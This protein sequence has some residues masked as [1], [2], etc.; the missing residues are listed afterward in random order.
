MAGAV[1]IVC[2]PAG[3]GKT[4]RLLERFRQVAGSGGAALWLCPTRR[5]AEALA[6]GLTDFPATSLRM[7]QD[8]ADEVV[9]HNDPGARPFSAVQRRLLIESLLADLHARGRLSHFK[10]VIDTRGF[11]A[12]A[13]DLIAELK[14]NEIWPE[15]FAE[16]V[17][18]LPRG[19]KRASKEQQCALLYDAYQ[20]T[21]IR[22]QFYDLEGRVWYARDL[23][24]KGARQPFAEVRAVFLD[25]FTRFTRTQHEI[26]E[27]LRGWVDEL[28]I[29]LPDEPGE[30]RAELFSTPR[31][32]LALLPEISD[33][34]RAGGVSPLVSD[35]P[36]GLRPPLARPAGL[37]HLERQ[38]FRPVRSVCPGENAEGLLLIEAPGLV[39]EVRMVARQVK[40]LLLAGVR[41]D[42]ILVTMRDAVPYADLL[43][44][45]FAEYGVP[46]DIE[47]AEPIL[48]NPAVATLLRAL[49][50]P[51]GEWPFGPV[52][53]LL[54]STY[55]RPNWPEGGGEPDIAQHA[56]ALLRLLG[57]PRGR[58]AYLRAVERWAERVQPG[59]EDED[60]EESR[61][62]R[63]H[64]LAKKCRPFLERLFRAWDDFPTKAPLAE[65]AAWLFRFAEDLGLVRAAAE[66]PRDR[67][68][69]DR[70]RDELGRWLDTGERLQLSPRALDRGRFLR[71]LS[72]LAAE[73]GLARAPR[74]PGRVRVLS[75]EL[76]RHLSAAYLFVMGLGER[77]FP[78]LAPALPLLDEH[79]R[80]TLRQ[81]GL[82]V[83][84]QADLMA[85]EMLLFYQ[86]VTQA[87]RALVLSYPA[88]DDKGQ[89]LL[90]SSFLSTVLDCFVPGAV[91]RLQKRM[92]IE[93][94]DRDPPLSAGEARVWFAAGIGEPG[95]SATGGSER[96][97]APVADA[98][99]SPAP[100]PPDLEAHLAAAAELARRRFDPVEH[101]P[102]DGLFRDPA[103][104]AELEKRF[105]P[106]SVFSPTALESYIA[107]PFRFFLGHVLRL[108]PLE[109]PLEEIE[110]ADRGLAFHR[111]LS[112]LHTHLRDRGIDLPDEA[113][114]GL[115]K[116]Q[117]DRAVEECAVRASLASEVLWR[118]E[119]QRL[120]RL[121]ERYRP[122]WKRFIEPW[123]PHGLRPRPYRFEVSFGLPSANGDP[124]AD[125]LVIREGD[126]EV[127]ISGRIDRV[128]LA[129]LP[130]EAR[131]AYGFWVIDYKTGNP[132]H[133]TGAA[134][135][136]FRRLQLTLYALAVEEV[137]LAGKRARPLGLAYW[138]VADSGPKVALPAHPQKSVAWFEEVKAWPAL[139]RQLRRWVLDLAG[140]IRR[141]VFPLKPRSEDC[142]LTCD[143]G[144]V[145]RIGQVRSVVEKKRWQLPL[146]TTG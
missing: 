65:Y 54:R 41:P 109:E 119:G 83:A 68:A 34:R 33:S 94:Y 92:L 23:V 45:V 116:E 19:R 140:H 105:G 63:T 2:G 5:A 22:H 111:A 8:F 113:V 62:R 69:Q 46:L 7:F 70:L 84:G 50:L 72:A 122:H 75:A 6:R 21:L 61:R 16:A 1:H 14:R 85:G 79:E 101:T 141:G 9:R 87:R 143:F 56:E 58:V 40:T 115:L 60:A 132:T 31:A 96:S 135:K 39:G 121:A 13:S 97:L 24:T 81:A 77:S 108:N 89:A 26:I 88:V 103:V 137:L 98:P 76:A 107:C 48:R 66:D 64:E 36:G 25:G 15:Q 67:A 4:R 134:L 29:T 42:D 20:K 133:Y 144:Q 124:A 47:G 139:R 131:E 123:L 59:L 90:P 30:E 35:A 100:L 52:T 80:Q 99:G 104:I 120:K 51:E 27:A 112:R 43:R 102:Y 3:S 78:R 32:A 55:F 128:D 110:S 136:E 145:C 49:R 11:I 142:T 106:Q 118:L 130:D 74:G 73:A 12:T 71:T 57:E 129:E 95:A 17:G 82:P 44:E 53:A 93:G 28:W 91:P 86:V 127:R 138:L 126:D 114:D 18:G 125:P 10:G 146:P 38:L 37:A 117:L